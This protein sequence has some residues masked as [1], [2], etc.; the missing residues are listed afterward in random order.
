MLLVDDGESQGPELYRILN[1]RMC[2]DQDA[3]AAVLQSRMDF[4]PCGGTRIPG[5]QSAL[6]ARGRKVFGD[7]RK[8]LL[9][10]DFGR[11]HHA[12]LVTVPHSDEGTQDRDHGLAG[13]DVPLQQAVHLMAAAHV[14][15]DFPD[16]PFLGIGQF[17][18]KR[19]VA[20]VEGFPDRRHG[21]AHHTAAA[22]IFLL[23]EGQLQKEKLLKFKPIR[24]FGQGLLVHREMDLPKGKAER[25]QAFFPQDILGKGFFQHGQDAFKGG[26]HKPCHHPAGDAGV[27]E[28]LRRGVYTGKPS[29]GKGRIRRI[30]LRMHHVQ[31]IVEHRR[32]AEEDEHGPGNQARMHPLDPLEKDDF[33]LAAAV[34]DDGLEPG[35]RIVLELFRRQ[36]RPVFR[37]QAHLHHRGPHLYLRQVRVHVGN[38]DDGAAVDVAEG[39]Q[40]HKVTDRTDSQFG[41]Q[42]LRPFGTHARQIL[43]GGIHVHPYKD[44]IFS[45]SEMSLPFN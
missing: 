44:T 40:V 3:D 28:F 19:V 17:I 15:A 39:I 13:T 2:A 5:E 27:L 42:K 26:A 43:Y 24:G 45:G 20:S 41:F 23:E 1:Q 18:R 14:L 31:V 4:A 30:H 34:A 8:V 32:L 29:A 25:N 22:D 38:P 37:Q 9:G 35:N 36:F 10:K 33:H 16:D 21:K 7:I 6:H 11:G 12:G